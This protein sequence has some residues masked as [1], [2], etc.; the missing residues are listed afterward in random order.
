MT[1]HFTHVDMKVIFQMTLS[2]FPVF[3][4]ALNTAA[5]P[6]KRLSLVVLDGSI[7]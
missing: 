1:R 5:L 7:A 6:K 3:M 2:S 4:V